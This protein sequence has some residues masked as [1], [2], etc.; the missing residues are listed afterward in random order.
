MKSLRRFFSRLF[1]FATRR[2]QE[3]RLR[4]EIAEHVALQTADNIRGGMSPVE[5]RR[6]A[7]IKFGGV[8]SMTEIHRAERGFVLL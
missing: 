1:S 7:L 4:D 8:E 6:Q 3:D 2:V 5:A